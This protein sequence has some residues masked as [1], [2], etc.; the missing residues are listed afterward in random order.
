MATTHKTIAS[1]ASLPMR[2]TRGIAEA[3]QFAS[4]QVEALDGSTS[5]IFRLGR[6]GIWRLAF[7]S[8]YGNLSGSLSH[9]TGTGDASGLHAPARLAAKLTKAAS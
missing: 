9:I 8:T 7:I 2:C 1:L 4:P 3:G 6:D 5:Y